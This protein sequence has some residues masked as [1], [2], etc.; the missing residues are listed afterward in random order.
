MIDFMTYYG[1]WSYDRY[2]DPVRLDI[3]LRPPVSVLSNVGETVAQFDFVLS[4]GKSFDICHCWDENHKIL[5]KVNSKAEKGN[6]P[7]D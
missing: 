7:H 3:G 5:L 1:I 6:Q 2:E 4:E